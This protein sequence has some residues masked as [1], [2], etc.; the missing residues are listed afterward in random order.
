[1]NVSESVAEVTLPAIFSDGM[2]LQRELPVPVWGTANPNE[3]VVVSFADQTVEANAD[4]Q[5]NWMVKLAPLS[6][7][8]EGRTLTVT[9]TNTVEF[10]NVLV[11]EVWLCSGQSNMADS[12]NPQ[13]KRFIPE[14]YFKHDLSRLRISTQRGW[15]DV[16]EKSQRSTSRVAFYFGFELYQELNIPIGLI[17]RYNSGTP[18]QSWM[19]FAAS[20][21]IRQKLEI[22][23][24][25]NDVQDNRN[26]A[27]QFDSK[28][29][30]IVP[31]AFRGTIW[32][33]G[34]RNAKAYTG[35][36][37]SLIHI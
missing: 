35:W 5:G 16:N 37:L 4:A 23:E 28:I 14:S 33:Q 3:R 21:E 2:V 1:M 29:A 12:F 19:P 24:G 18:I 8:S 27:V 7:S 30:P 13:K 9:G 15:D 34:E 10:S 31:Y 17:L 25:W 20:E 22:P 6:T 32:Y 26:P 11:G 36:E